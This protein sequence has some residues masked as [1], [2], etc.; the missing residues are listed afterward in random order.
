MTA[1]VREF[2]RINGIDENKDDIVELIY[3][4]LTGGDDYR[5]INGHCSKGQ[6]IKA[7]ISDGNTR[8][9]DS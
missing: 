7:P 5:A 2:C 8:T 4:A 9:A 3:S 1:T 6:K